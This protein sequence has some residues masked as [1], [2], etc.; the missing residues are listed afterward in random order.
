MVDEFDQAALFDVVV[1]Q[2]L[3]RRVDR[4]DRD[5]LGFHLGQQAMAGVRLAVALDRLAV[6]RRAVAVGRVA[7]LR[8]LVLVDQVGPFDE[9]A[10]LAPLHRFQ[11]RHRDR[12]AVA[13]QIGGVT[14]IAAPGLHRRLAAVPGQPRH[15]AGL[16]DIA[17]VKQA[18]EH[19]Q[20]DKTAFAALLLAH[21]RGQDRRRRHRAAGVVGRLETGDRRQR[22][23]LDR[24]AHQPG[25]RLDDQIVSR[26]PRQGAVLAVAGDRAIDD[27]G[28]QGARLLVMHV[29]FL[30]DA[31]AE[32]LH[33][34][35]GLL[36]QPVGYGLTVRICEVDGD[37]ALVRIDAVVID[38]ALLVAGRVVPA[39]IADFRLLDLDNVGAEI[40]EHLRRPRTRQQAAEVDYA[41][42]GKDAGITLCH[43]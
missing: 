28:V 1:G 20:I 36:D 21:Q 33:D 26:H 3:V 6:E 24:H 4:A 2:R 10:E 32:R 13:A 31:G 8:P 22:L 40:G 18:I 7:V 23:A 15:A 42:A 38:A 19:R 12:L 37:A 9:V 34:H 17:H 30:R 35:V 5:L 14:R 29:E 16:D 39:V 11:Q 25:H 43:R 41:D 27:A